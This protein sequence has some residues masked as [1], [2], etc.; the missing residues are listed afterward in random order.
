MIVG[1]TGAWA[2]RITDC[3]RQSVEAII[4]TGRLLSE[5]KSA[6]GHGTFSKLIHEEL[7]FSARTAQRL[8]AI[9][10]DP[11]LTDAT[12]VSLLPPHWGTL[13]ELTRLDDG[14]FAHRIADGT[15][16]PDMDRKD[17]ATAVRQS[18]RATRELTLGAKI[19]ALPQKKYGVIYADPEWRFEPWSRR[20]GMDRAADNHYP[21]SCTEVIA[22]RDVPLIAHDHSVLF[23]WATVPMLPHALVVME[24]WGFDY[25]S[26]IIWRKD[27]TGTGYWARNLH[28]LF[29]IGVSGTHVPAPAPGQN[30]PSVIDA[31]VGRH[32]EKP[33]IFLEMIEELYPTLPKIEL[34][35]RSARPGWDLWGNEVPEQPVS[36]EIERATPRFSFLPIE[37]PCCARDE[38]AIDDPLDIP[39]FLRRQQPEEARR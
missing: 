16:R 26:H 32:S 31:P 23:L 12:H 2:D 13:Y 6:L 30:W 17:I 1:S 19:L 35:A 9:A 39:L 34:N 29:L 21:T 25:R 3:W 4:D 8:M 20:T 15:I 36:E 18:V 24:T 27:K 14:Q 37:G 7:P 28:E 22:A 10:S 5:A 11:R 38:P 33:P